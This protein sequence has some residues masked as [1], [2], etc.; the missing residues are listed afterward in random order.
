MDVRTE[1]YLLISAVPVFHFLFAVSCYFFCV[2]SYLCQ[3]LEESFVVV[4]DVF[5]FQY[6]CPDAHNATN[7]S[8]WRPYVRLLFN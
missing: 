6:S 3:A 7:F 2:R 5:R 1:V 8:P 4:S